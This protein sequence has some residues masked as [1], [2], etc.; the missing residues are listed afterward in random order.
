MIYYV[1]YRAFSANC[2]QSMHSGLG[3]KHDVHSPITPVSSQDDF[4]PY[5]DVV[6]GDAEAERRGMPLPPS[7]PS[8][9][10]L[11]L[12][13]QMALYLAY[14]LKRIIFIKFIN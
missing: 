9:D 2:F 6:D 12:A 8:R 11:Y 14:V 7:F 3:H 1:S 5:G 4:N 10:Y 13:R